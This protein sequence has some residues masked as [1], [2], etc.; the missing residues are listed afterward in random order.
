MN[1]MDPDSFY[2]IF[3][4]DDGVVLYDCREGAEE[5]K[6]RWERTTWVAGP[7]EHDRIEMGL[8]LGAQAAVAMLTRVGTRIQDSELASGV[9]AAVQQ[10]KDAL[11][12]YSALCQ[13]PL[14]HSL[15][16]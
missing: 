16:P 2:S 15:D 13:T 3:S 10:L 8:V 1:K 4:E 5:A 6:L 9:D 7:F 12:S 14:E 11:A